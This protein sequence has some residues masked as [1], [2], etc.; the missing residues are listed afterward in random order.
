MRPRV[1]IITPT[2]R[3][4]D[5]IHPCI[6]SVLA[7]DVREWEMVVVDDGSDDGTPD[8]VESFHDPRIRLVRN[9]HHGLAALGSA[10]AT[11]LA[12]SS[13][14]LIAVLEGDDLWPPRKLSTQVPMLDDPGVVLAYG[15][16]GL[17]DDGG[18]V[19]AR[20]RH[21]PRGPVARNEPLGSIAPALIRTDFI[22]TATVMVRRSAL[23]AIGGFAQPPGIPYVDLPTWLRLATQGRFAHSR[24]ILGYWRRHALQWTIQSVLD[25]EPDRT[26]YLVNLAKII[27][28]LLGPGNRRSLWR[29]VEGDL[30]RRTQEAAM[31]RARM[32]LLM[33]NWRS[34]SRAWRHLLLNGEPRTRALAALGLVC[35]GAHLDVE[36]AIRVLGRHSYP[37]R[38]RQE[39]A[40]G[41]S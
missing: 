16:A 27:E 31:S 12:L 7:Q 18:Q 20:H 21:A 5:Y 28:P 15:S 23:D 32:D 17:V 35:G 11:G 2:F 30:A 1:A 9:Q 8:I 14:P 29:A 3:H 36:W 38:V 24:E 40:A 39:R 34:A 19:Y 22:V 41:G 10:Y 4:R 6:A 13:S 25:T 37:R 33:G 26:E